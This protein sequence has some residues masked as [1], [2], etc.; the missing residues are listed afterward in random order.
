[1]CIRDR[2]Q[3]L[4][5]EDFTRILEKVKL[6]FTKYKL[7]ELLLKEGGAC[8]EPV[9]YTDLGLQII[10]ILLDAAVIADMYTL[11]H[12]IQSV[13]YTHLDVYKRQGCIA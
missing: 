6:H 10:P 13:S 1:M 4:A 12:T 8:H 7:G 9:S 11:G 2:F 5:Q 3:G